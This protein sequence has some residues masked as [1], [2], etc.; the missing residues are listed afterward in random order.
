[1]RL[2]RSSTSVPLQF[3]PDEDDLAQKKREVEA[4]RVEFRRVTGRINFRQRRRWIFLTA[5]VLTLATVLTLAVFMLSPTDWAISQQSRFTQM[6]ALILLVVVS[7]PLAGYFA[8]RY[9]RQ[10]ERVRIARMRQQEILQRLS[11]LDDLTGGRRRRRRRRSRGWVWRIKHPTTF[12]RPPLES[13]DA[14]T[15]EEAADGLGATLTEERGLRVL[16]YMHAIGTGGIV[17]ALSFTITLSGPEY[18][19]SFL[20]GKQW[21]GANGLDP[22]VFWLG[23]SLSLV[24]V[25]GIGWHRVS[26]LLRHARAYQDRLAAVERALWDARVLLRERR[27]KV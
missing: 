4:L 24:A 17:V 18:L 3:H 22:M 6:T 10:R 11:Q 14:A 7:T 16:A 23:L 12:S 9:D 26:V 27:E 21:G 5:L 2:T 25:G 15:L 19:T 1:M 20:G 13:M 8:R